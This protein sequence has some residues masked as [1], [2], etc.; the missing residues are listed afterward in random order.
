MP[1]TEIGYVNGHGT[2]TKAGDLAESWATYN[3][4]GACGCIEAWASVQMA[5]RK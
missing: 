5:N 4:L 1:G 3:A 2:A